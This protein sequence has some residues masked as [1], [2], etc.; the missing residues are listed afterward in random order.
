MAGSRLHRRGIR[1]T[2]TQRERGDLTY[3]IVASA[4]VFGFLVLMIFLR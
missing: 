2:M 4:F 3:S 1:E